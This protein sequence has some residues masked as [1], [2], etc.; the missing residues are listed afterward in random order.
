MRR[1]LAPFTTS[2][3]CPTL[4]AVTIDLHSEDDPNDIA[5]AA[6]LL[7]SRKIAGTFF[8]PTMML[9]DYA[10]RQA[11]R[12]L[13]SYG[14]EIGTHGH[15]HDWQEMNLLA[16]GRGRQIAFLG[17]SKRLFEDFYGMSPVCFRS[18]C[19]C[20]LGAAA[21]DELDA[22]GYQVDSS[23]T[24]QRLPVFSS[25]PYNGSWAFAPRNPYWIR[26]RLLEVP[27][28]SLVLPAASPTFSTLGR[29]TSAV[30]IR[31][32]L[33]ESRVSETIINIQFHVDDLRPEN[34]QKRK[35]GRLRPSDFLLRR[36]GGFAFKHHLR[37][38]DEAEIWKTTNALL[39]LLDSQTCLNLSSIRTK[40]LENSAVGAAGG[41]AT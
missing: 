33:I 23:S 12:S 11:L 28:T 13:P 21:L 4:S 10:M 15:T 24:P 26:K 5:S 29:R 16:K 37:Q 25:R 22:L 20:V 38:R 18:P 36:S 39:S 9:G 1:L 14:H 8:V 35:R 30:F 7:A 17:R 6:E 41:V 34:H 40:F 27:T 2:R 32:A 31:L 19:W 3:S